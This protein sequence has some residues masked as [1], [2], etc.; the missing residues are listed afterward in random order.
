MLAPATPS[1]CLRVHSP[2][3]G[4]ASGRS[5]GSFEGPKGGGGGLEHVETD[6]ARGRRR[7]KQRH[8]RLV[9]V[10]RATRGHPASLLGDTF[11]CLRSSRSAPSST[12]VARALEEGISHAAVRYA[13]RLPLGVAP[14][15]RVTGGGL[16]SRV[17]ASSPQQRCPGL[18]VCLKGHLAP[19][20]ALE[21]QANLAAASLQGVGRGRASDN[22]RASGRRA[23]VRRERV[24]FDGFSLGGLL[25]RVA[26]LEPGRTRTYPPPESRRAGPS[27]S[28]FLPTRQS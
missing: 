16:R 18:P 15:Q 2:G 5:V 8:P 4:G 24:R 25:P 17:L 19:A 1:A 14:S 11:G 23:C 10:E 20:H 27:Y 7:P 9:S 12:F 26:W 3:T 6:L 13:T 22:R 21:A 28:D